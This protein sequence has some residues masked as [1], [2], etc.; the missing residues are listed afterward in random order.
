ME[1][2]FT[3]L[4][5]ESQA[6]DKLGLPGQ[7]RQSG[8]RSLWRLMAP[9]KTRMKRLGLGQR[10]H[11]SRLLIWIAADPPTEFQQ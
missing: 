9:E 11:K 5:M 3:R 7:G 6:I 1:R 2:M 10:C 4:F 8:K